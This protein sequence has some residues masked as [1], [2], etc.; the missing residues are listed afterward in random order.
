M[1][2]IGDPHMGK[3]FKTG[4]PIHRR[5]DREKTQLQDLKRNLNVDTKL[6]VMVGDLFDKPFV[7]L[8]IILE[9]AHL[10]LDA[11]HDHPDTQ[12]VVMAGN[13]DL[14]RELDRHGAFYVLAMI[15]ASVPNITVVWQPMIISDVIFFPWEWNV[16]A[17]DQVK[18]FDNLPPIAVG[19]WDLHD[20]GGS[21][22]HLCPVHAL[23]ARGVSD[24]YSGHFHNAGV[25]TIDGIDIQC[26]GSM[27][28]YS[29]A[30][31]PSGK[32]YKTLTLDELKSIDTTDMNVRLVL[33]GGEVPPELDCLS[34]VVLR[35][36]N[37]ESIELDEIGVGD[38]N[39]K[40]ALAQKFEEL[41]VPVPVQQFI[42]EKTGVID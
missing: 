1:H 17:L 33:K 24:I 29:H 11:S 10:Y 25:Y 20:F 22:E 9:V 41:K 26:T 16:P 2:L 12:F 28:P 36:G 21:V 8:D 32:L 37:D 13:H 30:E 6:N 23:R 14:S 39:L 4:V 19:H 3:V 5:G 34:L 18:Q 35:E 40:V 31:D 27:Q 42:R 38:F 7:S 15:L